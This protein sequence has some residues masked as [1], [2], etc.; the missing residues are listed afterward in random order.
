MPHRL[1]EDLKSD[2]VTESFAEALKSLR[3]A[4][5]GESAQDNSGMSQLKE[6]LLELLAK[7]SSDVSATGAGTSQNSDKNDLSEQDI[8]AAESAALSSLEYQ[9]GDLDDLE[10][11]LLRLKLL[12]DEPLVEEIL[13]LKGH[14]RAVTSVAFAPAIEIDEPHQNNKQKIHPEILSSSADGTVIRWPA[15]KLENVTK[16]EQEINV[17]K[18]VDAPSGPRLR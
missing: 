5:D 18:P 13:T 14:A 7:K 9:R 4:D 16:S 11:D 3:G 17:A 2:R 1:L 8:A 6:K 10:R 15:L 12:L